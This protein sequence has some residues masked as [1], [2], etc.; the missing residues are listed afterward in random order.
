MRLEKKAVEFD[1]SDPG[2]G[3]GVFDVIYSLVSN[4]AS[5]T[6]SPLSFKELM[7]VNVF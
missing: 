4:V 6:N 5:I 7:L 2:R 1:I 3:F